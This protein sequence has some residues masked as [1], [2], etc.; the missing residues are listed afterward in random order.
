MF[1]ASDAW[2]FGFGTVLWPQWV[3][4]GVLIVV[5]RTKRDCIAPWACMPSL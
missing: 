3:R 2:F 1:F 5:S 4:L